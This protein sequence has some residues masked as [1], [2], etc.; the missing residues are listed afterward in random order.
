MY[1]GS[2]F[3]LSALKTA[4]IREHQNQHLHRLNSYYLAKYG[5]NLGTPPTSDMR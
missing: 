1:S 3:K 2:Q 5:I 4:S